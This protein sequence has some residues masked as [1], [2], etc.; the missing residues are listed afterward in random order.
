[1]KAEHLHNELHDELDELHTLPV[2]KLRDR[3]ETVFAEPARSNNRQW[4]VRR[5]AWRLQS[6]AEGRFTDRAR[7]RAELL[8]R[9]EDLRVR[10]PRDRGPS[11]GAELRTVSGRVVG[12]RDC[13]LPVP[14]SV[15]TRDYK[16][17]EHRVLVLADGFEYRG[18]TY[19]SLSAVA[20]AITGSHWNGY[21]F[22]GLEKPGD[23][24]RDNSRD[25]G[26][27]P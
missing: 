8:A 6:Q 19:R 2:G 5:I 17:L 4:L 11:L 3:Y 7:R 13:R 16:G 27:T 9:D 22:F 20:H 18:I 24:G 15:L 25:H 14:G 10:P 26:G 1:M 23:E 12:G 21:R